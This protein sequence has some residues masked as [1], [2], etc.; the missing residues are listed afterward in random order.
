MFG[1]TKV[2]VQTANQILRVLLVLHQLGTRHVHQLDR[3]ADEAG[4]LD[5]ERKIRPRSG[6]ANVG[7]ERT[8]RREN[9]LPHVR[10]QVVAYGDRRTHDAVGLRV[11]AALE[12]ARPIGSLHVSRKA[13]D[14]GVET[15]FLVGLD[16]LLG[17]LQALVRAPAV[18][19][20]LKE[21]GHRLAQQAVEPAPEERLEPPLDV[22]PG[23]QSPVQRQ[24]QP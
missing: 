18:D 12:G 4:V 7:R 19:Q 23:H 13:V 6:E 5:I 22:Q 11:A 10:G 9:T 21:R 14:D 1:V 8:R 15:R 16:P 2:G 20:V 24:Q 3:H 17:E